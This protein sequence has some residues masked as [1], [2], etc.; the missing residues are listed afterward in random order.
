VVAR[1]SGPLF[2]ANAVNVK[3]QLLALTAASDPRPG[4][5]VLDLA[6]SSDLDVETL[7][8]L[9]ELRAALAA[10]GVELRLADVHAPAQELLRRS[11][12]ADRVRIAPTVDAGVGD[13]VRGSD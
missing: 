5:L 4:A 9:E 1:V 6:Q 11:G 8:V 13:P 10:D 7:D 3:E 2:Y 12:L